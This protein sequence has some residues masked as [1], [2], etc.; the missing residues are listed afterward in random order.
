VLRFGEKTDNEEIEMARIGNLAAALAFVGGIAAATIGEQ[1]LE[2]AFTG[3]TVVATPVTSGGQNFI[4]YEVFANFNGA[5]DTVLNVFNFTSTGASAGEDAYGNFWHK[6]NSDY[7]GGVLSTQYGTWAP[8]LVGSVT[9]N[10]PFDS[11][12]LIGGN[13]TGT[14]TSNADPSWARG[15]SGSHAGSVAGWSRPDLV[16]NPTLGWYNSSPPNFQGR[17]GVAPNTATAVKLGQFVLSQSETNFRTF[18]LRT[19]YNNGAGGGVVFA[20]GTFTLCSITGYRDVDGDGFGSAAS[21]TVPGCPSIPAGY[22]SNN[23]DCNDSNAAINPNTVWSRDVDGDG[24]G[25]AASGTLTQ[26][27]QPSGYVLNNLDCNDGNAAINPNTVWSRDLDGDGFGFAADGTLTQCAQPAGY[28][29]NNTDNCPSIANANQADCNSNGLGDVCEIAAGTLADCD[30]DGA[31]D[32]CEGAVRVDAASPLLAPFGNGFPANYTFTGLPKSY[33]GTPQLI[34]EATSDLGST[35]E[36][37]SISI[38]G[39]AQEFYFV[40]G[41]TDCPVAPDVET[42]TFT[43]PALN[44]LVADGQLSVV[45]T[46]SGTVDAAQCAGGGLRIRLRYDG[47]PS[48]ADCNGNGVLDSCEIGTGTQSDCNANGKP[49][50]CDIASGYSTDCNA[51]GVPDTC[52]I[53]TGTSTDL[54]ANGIPDECSGEFIVGGSGFA[55]VQ[56][57]IDAATNG[58][59]IRVAPGTYS[60]ATLV[61]S[62]RV[63]I[64]SLGGAEVTV[65]SGA[66][67]TTSILTF[68]SPAAAGSSV[69]GITFRDGRIGADF[70]GYRVGGA[71]AALSASITL[72]DC[73]FIDNAAAF[74][75]AVYAF[76]S[77]SVVRNC[78]FEGNSSSVDGGA[79]EIGAASDGWLVE[80]CSFEANNAVT[81]G[82][83]HM[84]S[85]GGTFRNCDFTG[86]MAA[87]RGGGISWYQPGAAQPVRLEGCVLELNAASEGGAIA[88]LAGGEAFEILNTRMC[89]NLPTNISGPIVDL[90]GNTFSQDCN[91]NGICDADEIAAGTQ[92]DCNANGIPDACDL[93]GSVLSWGD[94]DLGQLD[95]PPAY[96]LGELKQIAAGCGH[97]LALRADGTVVGWGA[98]A[99]GQATVPAGLTGVVQIAAGCDHNAALRA[100]GTVVCWG[101]NGFGQ[102]IV[103]TGL[104]NVVQVAA[105]GNHTAARRSDGTVVVWGRNVSGE[106]TVPSGLTNVAEIACGGAHTVARRTDGTVVCWGLNNFGQTT[107]PANVGTL[108]GITAGCYHTVGLRTDGTVV[109]WGSNLFGER[110]V[111]PNLTNV[112][113]VSAGVSLHTIAL[114]TDGSARAW[115]WNDFGQ[116]AVP[117]TAGPFAEVVA[118]GSHSFARTRGAADCNDNNL[119]DSCE[120]ASG[121]LADCDGDGVLDLCEITLDPTLDCDGNGVLNSCEI[122]SGAADCNS[123][124]KPDTCDLVAGT[125]T[126]LN[127]NGKLDECAGEYV[128]GGTGFTTIQAAVNAA[129]NGATIQVAAGT[130][131]AVDLTGR[132]LVLRSLA[133]AAAT[134]I[135]GGESARC[136]TLGSAAPGLVEIDGF[137]IRNGRANNGG[138]LVATLASPI[139]RNCIF[140]GNVATQNGGAVANFGGAPQFF[141]CD[142]TEN[143]AL[144]GGAIAAMGIDGSGAAMRVE[145]CDLLENVALGAGGAVYNDGAIDFVDCVIEANVAGGLGGGLFT[146]GTAPSR[147]A[148]TRLCRN[149]PNNT[150]GAYI[151]LGGN[152]FSDDCNANGLC[153]FDEITAGTEQ[154]CNTNGIPDSCDIANGTSADCNENGVPDSCDIASGSSTD[155]DS[156]GIPD[157]CKPDC[158]NDG[159]PDAWELAQG[160]DSDCN[161]NATIDRCEIAKSAALD[162][163]I[164]GVLDS[165]EIAA[166]PALDC[167]GN[168]VLDSCQIASNPALDCNGNGA[169]DTCDI[170]AGAVDC[171]ANG[172][173]DACDISDGAEDENDNGA[174]DTCELAR[175]DLDL[176]GV[177]SASDLSVLL[178]FWGAVNPPAGDLTG[179]GVINGADL[180]LLLSNWGTT[181]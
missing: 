155:V 171:D 53:A 123:N 60:S 144:Q 4:R 127:G 96:L 103:P 142:F 69:R 87:E 177:V 156:N 73:N 8:Q 111:P 3:Y 112:I 124:G 2:A 18:S 169:L 14:N 136:L 27:A 119:L 125:S 62:K 36:F 166:N 109:A 19:A 153:D 28:V 76:A 11:F 95:A 37:I 41:G 7:N 176:D 33:R 17:V 181:P 42:K 49:D 34:F 68:S 30:S 113:K 15:G 20:D 145:R 85:S 83:A 158:D 75:G 101:A 82:A 51:N 100:D 32:I 178:V 88:R 128:V 31:P 97:S 55:N 152:I 129:P 140:T 46:A 23:L 110:T 77:A 157:D 174:L 151:D 104:V 9:A 164:D 133:G 72:E 56:A 94:N 105:G 168:G 66:S 48:S 143:V 106:S 39:G 58:A 115:G 179:D 160:L 137:T 65:F 131:G 132:A 10:R 122:A 40:A 43:I 150:W 147:L 175:G 154:D 99:F 21:G 126:D 71:I 120:I 165:C 35:N 118:G 61:T 78:H 59:T 116:L 86:N 148:T 162:C 29:L 54:N 81:G 57:A 138:G 102:C 24:F 92:Q 22:V 64:E 1:R 80:N 13:P 163:D 159:L 12:L 117:S 170:A 121:A 172:R 47:L 45:I 114:K 161:A 67:L 6:D 135:D 180:S 25:A 146:I 79:L 134:F 107:V 84:W 98:N 70:G 91:E 38:D 52:D 130:Y 149:V 89:R 5:T 26:C 50:S 141:D 108:K 63:H 44:A 16:N 167:D 139:V 90:G 74:G 173:I 93:N